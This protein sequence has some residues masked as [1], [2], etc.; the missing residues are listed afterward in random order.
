MDNKSNAISWFEIPTIDIQRATKFY[1]TIFDIKFKTW[2]NNESLMAVFPS[3]E[4][5]I[6]GA[7]VQEKVM[8]TSKNGNM[9]YLNAD[10][11]LQIVVDKLERAGGELLTP[12]MQ[13]SADNGFMAYFRDTEGNTIGLHSNN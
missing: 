1:E 5:M 4:G 12:K 7:L 11:D 3:G 9:I 2:E 10:P 8:K 13:I 6:G